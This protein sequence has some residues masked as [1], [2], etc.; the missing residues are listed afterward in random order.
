MTP[1]G[2]FR[3]VQG[4]KAELE[5]SVEVGLRGGMAQSGLKQEMYKVAQLVVPKSEEASGLTRSCQRDEKMIL[6]GSQSQ[7]SLC[8]KNNICNF[9]EY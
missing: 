6:R 5:P 1:T 4:A 3:G 2:Y 7:D 9:V 8:N